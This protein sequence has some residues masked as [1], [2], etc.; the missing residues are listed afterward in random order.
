[1]IILVKGGRARV[2]RHWSHVMPIYGRI[3]DYNGCAAVVSCGVRPVVGKITVIKLLH[4]VTSYFFKVTSNGFVTFKIAVTS[5]C[6]GTVTLK[7]G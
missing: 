3:L 7:S 1:M 2:V 4:Y 6:N 5:N